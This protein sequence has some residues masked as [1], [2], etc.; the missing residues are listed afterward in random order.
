MTLLCNILLEYKLVKF[1]LK[2]CN[3]LYYN[4][5]KKN[6]VNLLLLFA[7]IPL[8]HRILYLCTQYFL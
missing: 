8:S 3:V 5:P 1:I 2:I 6:L 7:F 4:T